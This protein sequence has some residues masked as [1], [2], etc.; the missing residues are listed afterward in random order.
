MIE[1]QQTFGARRAR[2]ARR[3]IQYHT[4]YGIQVQVGT[5]LGT[6]V[7]HGA[8]KGGGCGGPP[9]SDDASGSGTAAS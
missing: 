5:Y 1:V 9:K 8:G 2:L 3:G 7:V 6:Y 4:M